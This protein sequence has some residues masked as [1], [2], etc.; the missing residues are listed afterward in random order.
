MVLPERHDKDTHRL[1]LPDPLPGQSSVIGNIVP[2]PSQAQKVR[3]TKGIAIEATVLRNQ[4]GKSDPRPSQLLPHLKSGRQ[5]TLLP[6][7]VIPWLAERHLDGLQE[8]LTEPTRI[9]AR[10]LIHFAASTEVKKSK[11]G[12]TSALV[13]GSWIKH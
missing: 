10:M 13:R 7:D 2:T 3:S 11:V 4:I 6:S 1:L 9:Q 12:A 5:P 8:R